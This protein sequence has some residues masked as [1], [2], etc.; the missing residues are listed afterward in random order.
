MHTF[1]LPLP[2]HLHR[3]LRAEAASADRPATELVR[4]ALE[5]WLVARRRERLAEEIRAYAE[6]AA[7]SAT[8]LDLDLEQA[9]IDTL[10]AEER[11]S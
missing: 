2:D 6:D 11:A 3:A 10:L 1:H 5:Q 4:Q 8:D 9:G 7:G